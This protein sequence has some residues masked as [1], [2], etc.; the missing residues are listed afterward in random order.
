MNEPHPSRRAFGLL[1]LLAG[2][3]T[4][5]PG[6]PMAAGEG[7]P[8][9]QGIGGTGAR[10][11]SPEGEGDR[12]IGGT[13]ARDTGVFG[14][15][16]RF[17]SIVVNDL[18]IGYPRDVEVRIDD[19]PATAAALKLGH[20]VRV[21]ARTTRNA[22]RRRGLETAR[23]EVLREVVGP[24]E[25]VAPGRL[26][27]LGQEVVLDDLAAVDRAAA[28]ARGVGAW[29]AVSGL[30]RGD[31]TVVA[32]LVEP[33]EPGSAR[34]AGPVR[35]GV[36]GDP[37]IAGLRLASLDQALVGGRAI[38]TGAVESGRFV[39]RGARAEG[40]LFLP[41]LAR[42]SV[43]AY[44]ERAGRELRLGSGQ[45]L[46]DARLIAGR[47]V[48]AGRELRAVVT[49]RPRADGA[50]ETEA[51]RVGGSGAAPARPPGPGGPGAPGNP[52]GSPAP[53][54]FGRGGPGGSPGGV[55]RGG[56]GGGPG[57]GLG[58][59]SGPG[60]GGR[61]DIRGLD[62][63]TRVPGGGPSGPAFGGPGGGG[64]RPPGGPGGFGG[65]GG[66]MP[67]GPGGGGPRR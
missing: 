23:I 3:A 14:T 9:D 54:G 36:D 33:S 28:E 65:F 1:L 60:M 11:P 20:V 42:L 59:P 26:V 47:G 45:R 25:R 18:R 62:I 2:T 55:P 67:P 38:V 57:G 12:G 31:G 40:A 10:P 32:S 8:R 24:I 50:F 51:V 27:V 29:V 7:P 16:R 58:G 22:G 35:R 34:V 61:P 17:G 19:G 37:T 41:R 66:G 30:R 53:G 63:D 21:V 56:P 4:L 13:G 15:I 52:G 39:A 43:E 44:V 5:A 49:S 64:F 46:V 6:R 48:P